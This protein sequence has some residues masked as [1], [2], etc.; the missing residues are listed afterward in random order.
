MLL[1]AGVFLFSFFFCMYVV[2]HLWVLLAAEISMPALGL[3]AIACTRLFS[4]AFGCFLDSALM[5]RKLGFPD[6]AGSVLCG[7]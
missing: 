5:L 7:F 6:C 3:K 1:I 2:V 4:R